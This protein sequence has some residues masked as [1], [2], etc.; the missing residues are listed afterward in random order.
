MCYFEVA[1]DVCV[2][3]DNSTLAGLTGFEQNSLVYGPALPPPSWH[4]KVRARGNVNSKP[5]KFNYVN[6]KTWASL[7]E[8]SVGPVKSYT[9]LP[10]KQSRELFSLALVVF[11]IHGCSYCV[12]VLPTI[13]KI[14]VDAKYLGAS[15]F[16][17]NCSSDPKTCQRYGI[18]GYPTLTAFRS[19]SWSAV[20]SC[21]TSQST[22]LRLDYH[23]PVV[24][25]LVLE[26]LSDV[27][28]PA[29]DRS[30][31]FTS[32]PDMDVDVRLVGTVYT[33][34]LAR[35][36]L[37]PSLVNKWY[38]FHCFQLI[39]ELLFGRVP[40][41]ATYTKDVVDDGS[42]VR[43][44]DE[45]L[46]LSKL[47]LQRSDGVRV[48]VFQ[49]GRNVEYTINNQRDSKLHMF[50]DVHKYDLPK[51][52]KCEQDH[53]KCT[54]IAV[55]FVHDHRRLPVLHMTSAAFHTKLGS[56]EDASF[57]PFAHNLPILIALTHRD[58][59][60]KDSFFLK[61]LTESAYALYREMVVVTL[62][63]EEFTHWASRF[64]PKDY[65]AKHAYGRQADQVPVLYHYP[66]LCIIRPDDHQHAA[67]YPPVEEL[68]ALGT[69]V[70][71]R[72]DQI[73][74]QQII[75]FAKDY[76]KDPAIAVVKTEYF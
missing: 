12:Q 50:H 7:I 61:E 20:G 17:H 36:Y 26:W 10:K 66:R 29:V 48:K 21:S 70:Q 63:I 42:K 41:Y 65:H 22:N 58:N 68:Q 24:A 39:C 69:R 53:K 11:L 19:L 57:E 13:E 45:D 8:Q 6:D 15:L 4:T 49:M 64:V 1:R 40:C 60:T 54:D 25:K 32:L 71:T 76:M 46:I 9:A 59:V 31:M 3:E 35:R 30:F 37:S 51:N 38:P 62:D 28:Q 55:R 18:T 44:K 56:E 34:T 74:S 5:V 2:M 43:A 73:N 14:S 72:L 27:S 33:R 75:K 52:F 23:G 16:I 67:F 47:E